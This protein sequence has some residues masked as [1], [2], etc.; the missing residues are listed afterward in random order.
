MKKLTQLVWQDDPFD[1]IVR[2]AHV[3]QDALKSASRS[4]FDPRKI[5]VVSF[6]NIY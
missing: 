4:S 6:A 5:I 1:M 3:L 2:R